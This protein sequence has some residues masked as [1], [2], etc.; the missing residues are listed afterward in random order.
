[1]SFLLRAIAKSNSCYQGK[2]IAAKV[3]ELLETGTLEKLQEY[4]QVEFNAVGV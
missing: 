2:G 3:D 4:E 1:M